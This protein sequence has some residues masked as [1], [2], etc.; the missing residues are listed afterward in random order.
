MTDVFLIC[1][2][3]GH[4]WHAAV[5]PEGWTFETPDRVAARCFCVN[6]QA[7]PPHTA[8]FAS[9]KVAEAKHGE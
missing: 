2:V 1:R 9:G 8:R 7:P 5:I 4:Q 6:C 3:C